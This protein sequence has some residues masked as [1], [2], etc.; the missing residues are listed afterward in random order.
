MKVAMRRLAARCWL[1]QHRWHRIMRN[2]IVYAT[3][4]LRRNRALVAHD[5]LT[6]RSF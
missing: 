6:H 1:V 4:V 3:S 5:L 2:S